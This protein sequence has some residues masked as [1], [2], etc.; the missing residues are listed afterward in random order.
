MGDDGLF[1]DDEGIDD[2]DIRGIYITKV[3]LKFWDKCKYNLCGN[4]NCLKSND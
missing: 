1:I 4:N 2:E 3:S